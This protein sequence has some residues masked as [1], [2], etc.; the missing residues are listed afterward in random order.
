MKRGKERSLTNLTLLK[1]HQACT[2]WGGNS[3]HVSDCTDTL[4]S[5]QPFPS[6][7][8]ICIRLHTIALYAFETTGQT[9]GFREEN[10]KDA[11]GCNSLLI[12]FFEATGYC[13]CFKKECAVFCFEHI[14]VSLYQQ[15]SN[16]PLAAC[17]MQESGR[18]RPNSFP[19]AS[20]TA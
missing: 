10:S 9:E 14:S 4:R 17:L 11:Q 18:H 7:K 12:S 6:S 1:A 8:S 13:G 2:A 16:P 20:Q 19:S 3:F 5:N 15:S